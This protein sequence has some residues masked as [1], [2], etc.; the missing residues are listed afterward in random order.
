MCFGLFREPTNFHL[1]FKYTIGNADKIGKQ[2]KYED[3][4]V[5]SYY[6]G[7]GSTIASV[8]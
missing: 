8:A 2:T 4:D 5:K 6:R 1:H 3:A 7:G